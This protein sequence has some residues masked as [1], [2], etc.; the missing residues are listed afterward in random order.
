MSIHRKQEEKHV[1]DNRTP[2]LTS[3]DE[4]SDADSLAILP[5]GVLDPVYQAKIEVL[6]RA[7]QEIGFGR[8]QASIILTPVLNEFHFRGPFL[9]FSQGLG[10]LVGAIVFGLGCDIWGRRLSFNTTLLIV[11]IFATAAAGAPTY[12]VLCVFAAIWSVGVGGNLPVDTCIFLEFLPGTHQY[13]LTVLSIWWAFGQLLASLVA[14]AILPRYSCQQT[15]PHCT[16]EKNMG[17]RYYVIVMGAFMILLWATR[18]FAFTLYESPKYL[19]GRGRDAEAVEIIHKVAKYNS[20]TSTLTL[21][22]LS[23]IDTLAGHGVETSAQAAIRRNAE[24]FSWVHIKA[25]FRTR[26]MAWSTSLII[27]TWAIIGLAFP[28]YTAFLPYY[29]ATRG[30]DFGDGSVNT[31]YRNEVILSVLGLP[32]AIVAGWLVDIR[33]IGRKGALSLSTVLTGVLLFA[34]TTARTSN[35]L[36]GW[37]CAY[38]FT[39][40][41]MYGVLYAMTPELFPTKDRGT[42]N[43]LAS[44]ANRIFGVMAPIIALYANLTRSLLSNIHDPQSSELILIARGLGLRKVVCTLLQIYDGPQ[45]LVLLVNSAPEEEKGIGSELGVMGVRNPG[46]R[47]VDYEMSKKDRQSMY[48][49]GGL[50]SVTSRILVVDLLQ[51]DIPEGFVKAFSDQPEQF[52][53]GMFPLKTVMTELHLRKTHIYPR[54]HQEVQTSLGRRKA[55]VVELYVPMTPRMRDIHQAIVQCMT[56]TL[57]ELKRSNTTV[58]DFNVENA[59]FRSFD[60][61]VRRQLDPVWHKVAFKTKQLANDLGTLRRLLTYLLTFDP[62][63]FH[64]YLETI[65]SSNATTASNPMARS[66][67]SDWLF[68]DAAHVIIS[69]A[70]AR[71]YT[72]DTK[73]AKTGASVN[74]GAPDADEMDDE[75]EVL[76]EMTGDKT[77][78][79]NTDPMWKRWMPKGMKPVLEEPRKW[80]VLAEVLLEIEREII[81]RPLRPME[82]GTNVVLVMVGDS[83]TA[84]ILQDFLPSMHIN[85]SSPGRTI[86]ERRLKSYL[87]WKSALFKMDKTS[88]QYPGSKGKEKE[89]DANPMSEALRMKDQQRAAARQAR[90][91]VRGGGTFNAAMGERDRKKELERTGMMPNETDIEVE[92]EA[93]AEFLATQPI[94]LLDNTPEDGFSA[95]FPLSDHLREET[96][97]SRDLPPTPWSEAQLP[98]F[99]DHYGLLTPEQVVV[100][101][102]YGDD[103]DDQV[104]SELRPR[105]I[106]MF[107]PNQDFIRRIEVYKSSNPGLAVRVYFMIYHLSSEEHKYLSGQRREKDAFER[108]IKERGSMLIPIYDDTRSDSTEK[109]VTVSSRVGGGQKATEVEPPRIIVDMREFR[110]SLPNLIDKAR[111][112]VIPATLTV[113]D[114]ILTPDMCVERKSV[115][116]LIQSFISGRLYTQ[117]ELMSAHYTYPILLI[118]FEESKSFGLQ[119][120]ADTQTGPKKKISEKAASVNL[121]GPPKPS[122]AN[123]SLIQSKLVLLTLTFPRLRVIWSSSPHASADIF[124]DLKLTFPE[125]DVLKAISMGAEDDTAVAEGLEDVNTLAEDVLRAL[126][127][128]GTKNLRYVMGRVRS[129]SAL[130]EMSLEEVQE[131]LGVEPGKQCYNFIHIGARARLLAEGDGG[132]DA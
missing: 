9:N 40:N 129:V 20:T 32:G 118:E 60:S 115:P 18:F 89:Q 4:V 33:G 98:E 2:T 125:P 128:V 122:N 132:A 74:P 49:K 85:A 82:P 80:G 114:Y 88:L 94:Q 121:S 1:S 28:L 111:M 90:R 69:T 34:S 92:A 97:A 35:A 55:D 17:W 61:I 105:F 24:K 12:I 7:I 5:K 38:T 30:A 65:V 44:T 54:F 13:L 63:S 79:V 99:D 96:P 31:T 48:K 42:G 19:V 47:I 76:D 75:W 14:W 11:G 62:I 36:L 15:D 64:S 83:R 107:D 109:L 53:Y 56:A 101:R 130:C 84:M 71:C 103:G 45:N 22:D 126:P 66:E 106:I 120:L 116:D 95:P 127:G 131:L 37:N 58:E 117:C 16:K 43:A 25:L 104:L 78:K 27:L 41:I 112:Q 70:K 10:L 113:G 39:S 6:N 91:R 46:L 119:T 73:S 57:N 77:G 81:A 51:K 68:T 102:S 21:E 124:K 93:I 86:L 67:K 100:V 59:Y 3:S 123:D 52:T 108:L 50:V 8:Y 72:M 110:S 26:R 87:F 29:L 23:S